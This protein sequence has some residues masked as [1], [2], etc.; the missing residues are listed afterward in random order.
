MNISEDVFANL[1]RE[2]RVYISKLEYDLWHDTLTG[3]LS[4]KPFME[5]C[6][7]ELAYAKRLRT[8]GFA[9]LFIDLNDFK[10]VNDTHGHLSG[11]KVLVEVATRIRKSVRIE[12]VVGRF[13]GDEFIVLLRDV[14]AKEEMTPIIERLKSEVAEGIQVENGV[15]SV[16]ISG[17]VVFGAKDSASME[18]LLNQADTLMYQAKSETD[19]NSAHFV[20]SE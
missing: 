8:K 6:E 7:Q 16:G 13:G 11:D 12:D 3:V 2:V 20:F 9:L 18:T 10:K 15:M 5:I 19:S 17:G 1:P 4:R 14:A